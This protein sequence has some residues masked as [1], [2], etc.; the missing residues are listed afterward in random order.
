MSKN[1]RLVIDDYPLTQRNNI[2]PSKSFGKV[3]INDM[4]RMFIV[5]Y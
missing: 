3:A 1:K 4:R 5:Y 2:S